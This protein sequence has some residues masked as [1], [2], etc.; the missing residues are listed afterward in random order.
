VGLGLGGKSVDVKR[1]I[2][3]VLQGDRRGDRWCV[4]VEAGCARYRDALTRVF[5]RITARMTAAESCQLGSRGP[6]G[7]IE[8]LRR[9][10]SAPGGAT[11]ATWPWHA[12]NRYSWMRATTAPVRRS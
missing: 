8:G 2:P 9:P 7:R 12:A 5:V 3:V 11:S 4:G 6:C 10:Y 1:D